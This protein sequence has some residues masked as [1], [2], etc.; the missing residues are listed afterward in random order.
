MKIFFRIFFGIS[1][2]LFAATSDAVAESSV[3]AEG[4]FFPI[5]LTLD[6]ASFANAECRWNPPAPVSFWVGEITDARSKEALGWV[7]DKKS[8]TGET[9]VRSRTPLNAVF[10]ASL[11]DALSRCG[12]RLAARSNEAKIRL[13]GT[14]QE[15][16]GSSKKGLTKG[17]VK[18]HV[19]FTLRLNFPSHH[20]ELE[21]TFDR[22][23]NWARPVAKK[24]KQLEKLLNN[25]LTRLMEDIL[26]SKNV[27]EWL[28][29]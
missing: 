13:S 27:N 11:E 23:E 12:H 18:G 22:E 8:L 5:T 4:D 20:D 3:A 1:F 6:R 19:H 15:F 21:L 17:G 24:P 28:S 16:S 25:L 2:F 7:A 10:K 14:I 26:E 29:K 9:E